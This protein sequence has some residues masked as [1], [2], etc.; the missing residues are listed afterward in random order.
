MPKVSIDSLNFDTDNFRTLS[1]KKVLQYNFTNHKSFLMDCSVKNHRTM[2]LNPKLT[3]KK[4][5]H[6]FID[7]NH[8]TVT[9]D[10]MTC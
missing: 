9:R 5:L 7:H 2:A 10:Q 3:A 8:K 4:L 1:Y 6:D